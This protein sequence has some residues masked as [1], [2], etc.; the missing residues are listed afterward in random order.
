MIE[1]VRDFMKTLV[2]GCVSSGKTHGSAGLVLWFLFA[3]GPQ[4]RVFCLAPTERQLKINLWGEIPRMKANARFSI[5]GDM[6]PLSLQYRISDDWFAMGFSPQDKMGVFGIH[7]PHDL[8]LIDDAQG[9]HQEIWDALENAMA[10]GT[11]K[12][13]ASC[14]PVVTSGEIYEALTSKRGK[15][16]VITIPAEETPNVKAGKVVIPGMITKEMMDNWIADYGWDSDFV[17]TKVRAILPKQEP[18]TLCPLDWIEAAMSREIR[19]TGHQCVL[20]VDVARFG[21]DDT[22]IFPL[23]GPQALPFK[24]LHGNDTMEI[25]GHVSNMIFVH[26]AIAVYIDV[27]GVGS[28]VVDRLH[29]LQREGKI[30]ES[31]SIV[32]VNVGEKAGD[33]TKFVN[34]R[35]EIWWGVREAIDPNGP[36]PISLPRNPALM[37]QLA[38]PKWHPQS[39]RRIRVESK[40]EMKKRVGKSPD[41]AD[42]LCLA[43]YH[44]RAYSRRPATAMTGGGIAM[45]QVPSWA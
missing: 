28:G 5:G 29:E 21:D 38:A 10:G 7:G 8:L 12:M 25:V 31:V 19:S 14:N 44:R 15:Y 4:S 45:P 13:M 24:L 32:G 43:A 22:V 11:T 2:V 41:I 18:D 36:V 37:A 23:A 34:L 1:S 33:E 26:N 3:F 35:S 16:N 20:G 6:M 27:I 42:A 40:D 9:L 39:D 30:P 17:R